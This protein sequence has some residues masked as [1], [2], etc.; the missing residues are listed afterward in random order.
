MFRWSTNYTP[1]LLA[2]PS[3]WSS[4]LKK[5]KSPVY[6]KREKIQGVKAT[7]F[8]SLGLWL[9]SLKLQADPS[10]ISEKFLRNLTDAFEMEN[11]PWWEL[12][13]DNRSESRTEFSAIKQ[14]LPIKNWTAPSKPKSDGSIRSLLA[15][16]ID[17]SK[18]VFT[19]LCSRVVPFLLTF[20]LISCS[21]QFLCTEKK[22][23]RHE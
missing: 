13:D 23:L 22:F 8:I 21:R 17:N 11:H 7:L 3:F 1:W 12:T 6:R 15:Q 14:N 20:F 5:I 19:A 4:L 18:L 2:T 16:W 10:E 9:V